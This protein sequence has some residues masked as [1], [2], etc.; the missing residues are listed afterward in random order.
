MSVSL[1]SSGPQLDVLIN[2]SFFQRIDYDKVKNQTVY[3]LNVKMLPKDECHLFWDYSKSGAAASLIARAME[4]FTFHPLT[5]LSEKFNV[6][7][8]HLDDHLL[9]LCSFPNGYKDVRERAAKIFNMRMFN[10]SIAMVA[11]GKTDRISDAPALTLAEDYKERQIPGKDKFEKEK[12]VPK[13]ALAIPVKKQEETMVIK[14]PE[15]V[16][17]LWFEGG[18]SYLRKLEY[19]EQQIVSTGNSLQKLG[20]D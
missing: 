10:S 16:N 5:K 4:F 14:F 18:G 13:D 12:P 7:P 17:V 15:A 2:P 1:K 6:Y 8:I 9:F 3:R 20:V 11:I 19:W